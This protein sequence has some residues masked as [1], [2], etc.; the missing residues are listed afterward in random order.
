MG[1][2]TIMY[3]PT[4]KQYPELIFSCIYLHNCFIKNP[5]HPAEQTQ[6]GHVA[7]REFSISWGQYEKIKG[8]GSGI[9]HYTERWSLYSFNGVH[10]HKGSDG[11]MSEAKRI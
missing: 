5:L 9:A 3:G 7:Y 6:L 10:L 1:E 4:N 11:K 2:C 8:S